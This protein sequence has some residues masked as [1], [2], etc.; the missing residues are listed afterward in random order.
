MLVNKITTGTT[1]KN[2]LEEIPGAVTAKATFATS[3]A[4]VTVDLKQYGSS[5]S[6]K[7]G[8]SLD[9]LNSIQI[10][11]LRSQ[12]GLDAV[13][14]VEDIGFEANIIEASEA[15][16]APRQDDDT[17]AKDN[18]LQ[19][20]ALAYAA[21]QAPSAK[22]SR[23]SK[24]SVDSIFNIEE[25]DFDDIIGTVTL[26]IGGMSC[27]VCTGQVQKALRGVHGVN[28]AAVNLSTSRARAQIKNVQLD[29]EEKNQISSLNESD[30]MSKVAEQCVVAVR[31]AGYE[32]EIIETIMEGQK[33]STKGVTLA[34]NAA[35]M[36]SQRIQELQ[37]WK[38]LLIVSSILTVP[39]VI[40]HLAS[41]GKAH[42]MMYSRPKWTEWLCFYLATPVQFGVGRRFYISA[43]KSLKNGV[44]GM[45]FLVSLG[46]TAAYT[47]SVIVF[48]IRNFNPPDPSLDASEKAQHL[49]P[50]FETGA[51]L[52]TFVT[53][54]KY[55]ESFARGK[56]AS[57]LQKLM[58]LQPVV[59]TK[60]NVPPNL[61]EVD[62][63]IMGGVKLSNETTINQLETTEED[64]QEVKTGDF[65]LVLPGAR[66]PTDAVLVG[67]D[68]QGG[69]SYVDESALSGEPFP[70]PKSIGDT[71]YGS[72]I[73]QF[74]VLLV[75]VTATGGDTVLSRIV[76]LV[77]EA[78][79]NH[80]PI[81]A[82]ADLVASIFAPVVIT[83]SCITFLAW[84][85]FNSHVSL[86][87]RFFMA[88]MSAISV[89]VI[90]CP[91]ALGLATPTAVMVGTG[92]GANNG[93]LIKGG[94]VLENAHNVD[95]VILDKTG[96]IT[97]GRAV[98]RDTISFLDTEK[99][100][101]PIFQN[102]P[103]KVQRKDIPLW[104]A[105]CVEQSSEHPI[106]RAVV[107]AAKALYGNDV[108]F[109]NDGYHVSDF[110][111]FPGSGV[112][113]LI[114]QTGLGS[115][116]VRVGKNNFVTDNAKSDCGEKITRN[117]MGQKEAE[118]LRNKGHIVIYVSILREIENVDI[119]RDDS[120]NRR[121]L[122]GV[123]GIVDSVQPNAATAVTALQSLGIDVWM[124]TGDH[125]LTA[126]SVAREV[127]IKETNVCA[128]VQPEGKADLV[129]RLQKKR[130]TNRQNDTFLDNPHQYG[131]VA[132]VGDGINDAVALARADVGIAIGA[133]TEI[134][135][136]A[137]DVVLVRSSLH[138][139]V[140]ALHL[141]KHVFNRIRLNFI[142]ATSY[143]IVALPFAAG[144]FYAWTDWKIP[145]AMAGLMMAFSSVSVVTSSLLLKMYS[146]PAI[147][148][149]G[150]EETGY[151]PILFENIGHYFR[152]VTFYFRPRGTSTQLGQ[153]D[154]TVDAGGDFYRP[155][156]SFEL[157]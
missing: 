30:T 143:N 56:T 119:F 107:N 81:Q 27:A 23:G 68:G 131:K 87:Q 116:R 16:E 59:A 21:L 141:S 60:A 74:S 118:D 3:Y 96:T 110:T 51:M 26:Q 70:V 5:L 55:L 25:D 52:L 35:R 109:A 63:T 2:A 32:C 133:G 157:S 126:H 37:A 7:E 65:L 153:T 85:I 43:Y 38:S 122:I 44:M 151:F 149:Y 88:L 13:E 12:C 31:K 76:R 127:G 77:E 129:S 137:A 58:E 112:E 10:N 4:S 102:M 128:G 139:V 125:E 49:M 136:E 18:I 98:L 78:Q 33:S 67:R 57:A 145:P 62:E 103:E 111:V 146:K 142:W 147:T 11:N 113:A 135:V 93:L 134:A 1:V 34:E 29:T 121:R 24:S 154:P 132:F 92:V 105:A 22:M 155:N 130:R 120:V 9:I 72:T 89:V 140:V 71:L 19:Q 80:A 100:D 79:I 106:A 40:I 104:L 108:T 117:S 42:Q 36:E 95:T 47:Y 138:D 148:E 28:N 152:R 46:T 39:L 90:A 66:I 115:W 94:A 8:E 14:A 53:L 15:L 6:L 123:L 83:L 64:I 82:K 124:C 97:T 48:G 17:N 73:N 114:S 144:L 91:C 99:V 156:M 50:T 41:M 75:R 61:L 69:S 84:I 45:D 54:G 150:I 101:D 86:E 20:D